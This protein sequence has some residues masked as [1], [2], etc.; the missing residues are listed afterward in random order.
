MSIKNNRSSSFAA[1]YTKQQ[2]NNMNSTVY[3]L[4][5]QIS[6][7]TDVMSDRIN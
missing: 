2:K 6:I 1:E 3:K 4:Y 7:E 5:N